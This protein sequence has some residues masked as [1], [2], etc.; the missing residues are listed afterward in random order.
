MD[1]IRSRE[2]M[3]KS[4]I[5]VWCLDSTCKLV[6][7]KCVIS[8]AVD[9]HIRRIMWIK[10]SNNNQRNMAYDLCIKGIND[11]IEPLQVR[12]DKGSQNR[13]TSKHMEMVHNA[14]WRGHI[15]TRQTHNTMIESY[16]RKQSANIMINFRDKF[17]WL[18]DLGHLESHD[19][20]DLWSL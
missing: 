20:T 13:L 16:W 3:S 15:Y 17:Q 11:H 14:Q 4:A 2:Y 8:S 19:N 12:V 6:K 5:A 10:F 7:H 9:R 18:E 1:F